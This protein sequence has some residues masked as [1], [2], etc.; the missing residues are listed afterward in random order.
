MYFF[1]KGRAL[2]PFPD[3]PV[4]GYSLQVEAPVGT[5]I[6]A[7]RCPRAVHARVPSTA[8]SASAHPCRLDGCSHA[9]RVRAPIQTRIESREASLRGRYIRVTLLV[10]PVTRQVETVKV[11]ETSCALRL[12]DAF[13]LTFTPLVSIS[14]CSNAPQ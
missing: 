7:S 4:L 10:N 2:N 8:A 3:L 5:Q 6:G 14:S 13:H 11:D 9:H 1:A 12:T